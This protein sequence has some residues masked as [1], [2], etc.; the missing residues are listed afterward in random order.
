MV[1]NA[2]VE[3]PAFRVN[4]KIQYSDKTIVVMVSE[5]GWHSNKEFIVR[6]EDLCE[7]KNL[8]KYI[9]ETYNRYQKV[10]M[11]D[12]FEDA[13]E[14]LDLCFLY[15]FRI[16]I[17]STSEDI[18]FGN[19]VDKALISLRVKGAC[20]NSIYNA[21]K[22]LIGNIGVH[23]SRND[24]I[25]K[26]IDANE[27]ISEEI[28]TEAIERALSDLLRRVKATKS[29]SSKVV[30]VAEIED[31]Y[32]LI[33]EFAEGVF[34]L[35]A[36]TGIGKTSKVLQPLYEKNSGNCTYVVHRRSIAR[37]VMHGMSH[38][39][40]DVLAFNEHEIQDLRIVVNSLIKHNLKKIT[41]KTSLLLVDEAQQTLNHIV[42]AKLEDESHRDMI[43]S[44]FVNL[45]KKSKKVVMSDADINQT[46]MELVG[47]SGR[48]DV[49]VFQVEHKHTDIELDIN[50]LEIVKQ[51]FYK[52]VEQDE[53]VLLAT[54]NARQAEGIYLNLIKKHPMK[55]ILLFT[56]KNVEGKEQKTFLKNVNNH[57]YD[58][59]IY[60][61]V[62]TSS[63]SIVQPLFT[64]H[65]GLFE[66]VLLPT[67]CLQ[68]LR[69]DRT[70]RV[71]HVGLK[72][73]QLR[74]YT[75][76]NKDVFIRKFGGDTAFDRIA[77]SLDADAL[78]LRSHFI[79]SF[80]NTAEIDGFRLVFQEAD[81]V[82]AEDG[83]VTGRLEKDLSDEMYLKGVVFA[84][85]HFQNEIVSR[86]DSE[87]SVTNYY[88][89]EAKRIKSLYR[90]NDISIDEIKMFQK[91]AL[92]NTLN[93]LKLS[94]LSDDGV[95]KLLEVDKE[96]YV[97]DRQHPEIKS[98]IFSIIFIT[99]NINVRTGEGF[100]SEN[101]ART[102]LKILYKKCRDFNKLSDQ[103]NASR[104]W[105]H[106]T[107]AT[108]TVNR[109]LR[110]FFRF[111][112]RSKEYR[113]NNVRQTKYYLCKEKFM[114][115]HSLIYKLPGC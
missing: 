35:K 77:A 52:S 29:I 50:Q 60:S 40:D 67:D 34:V 112:I 82:K 113:E 53:R 37:S 70:A 26:L 11:L 58:V 48:S 42:T 109:I 80:I 12:K 79:A 66:G 38:Y 107:Q 14:Y 32:K 7:T 87:S 10:L 23:F 98:E 56:K 81:K 97:R 36:P 94:M 74:N 46:L 4:R 41:G 61:P 78:Y 49:T 90:K 28:A 105:K 31:A 76:E 6:A 106:S 63:V 93:N 101:E 21:A 73:P 71:F 85:D 59:L 72:N 75:A 62:I 1:M 55:K 45:I 18:S 2:S 17:L 22:K 99:L 15:S 96:K 24:A 114:M 111:D 68:M 83:R 44:E 100:Y 9:G 84:L 104:K 16:I 103:I 25:Q 95:L 43:F 47:H 92:I 89:S 65:F 51:D 33:D 115:M 39:E 86:E 64:A 3:C 108:R 20:A 13:E 54:D 91:G 27:L 8:I 69:R 19:E 88:L 30:K 110:H 102:L 57:E 5:R